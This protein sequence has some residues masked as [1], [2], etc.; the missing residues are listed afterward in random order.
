MAIS[1]TAVAAATVGGFLVYT[2][3][4]DVDVVEGMRQIIGGQ[5]PTEG[6]QKATA[7]FGNAGSAAA[8]AAA[9]IGNAAGGSLVASAR[10]K[11]GAKYVFGAVGPKTYDCSGLL[12]ACLREIGYNGGKVPRFVTQTFAVWA[13]SQGWTKVGEKDIRT[14]DV[15]LKSGHMGI[16]ISNAEMIHAPHTG[17]VVKVGKIYTPRYMW[18][19]WRMPASPILKTREPRV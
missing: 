15:V 13:R 6:A 5:V 4:K 1:G 14:G 18:S 16:A 9:A 7:G 8:G 11:L 10:A 12:V 2:G 17:S 19:G 3:I